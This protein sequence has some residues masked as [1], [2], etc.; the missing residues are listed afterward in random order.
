MF[1]IY[2]I[3]MFMG[4]P[5][6]W[7]ESEDEIEVKTGSTEKVRKVWRNKHSDAV[8]LFYE[9][10]AASKNPYIVQY[11][12]SPETS[13]SLLQKLSGDNKEKLLVKVHLGETIYRGD[14]KD[15]AKNISSDFMKAYPKI[16]HLL[17]ESD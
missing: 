8:L 6:K 10:G 13:N 7:C 4:L 3:I 15:E 2:L 17:K 5:E 14:S 12:E 1:E 11:F 9:F 16:D